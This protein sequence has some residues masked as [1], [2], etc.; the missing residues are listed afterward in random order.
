M[1]YTKPMID[2]V[3]EIRRRVD[4]DMKPSVKMAN[5]ELLKELADYHQKTKD[6]I[7]KALIKELLFQAG[8]QWQQLLEPVKAEAAKAPEIPKQVVKVYRG[9]TILVDAPRVDTSRVDTSRV[10]KPRSE[11][12]INDIPPATKPV[13]MYRGHPVL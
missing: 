12:L 1:Q 2:L 8:E 9:Q 6:T 13:R 3:Y 5:P 11:M 4:A 7:T 10:D